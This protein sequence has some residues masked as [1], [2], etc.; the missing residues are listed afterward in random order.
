MTQTLDA[1]QL[2]KGGCHD[3]DSRHNAGSGVK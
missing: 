2:K 3:S 1:A